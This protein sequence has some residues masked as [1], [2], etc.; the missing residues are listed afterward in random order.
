MAGENDK[1]GGHRECMEDFIEIYHREPCLWR[2]K[3]QCY[4]DRNMKD[5]AYK[6]LIIIYKEID[7]NATHDMVVKKNNLRRAYRKELKKVN[8]S[9]KSVIGEDEVYIPKLWYFHFFDFL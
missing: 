1:R 9:K 5:A 7:P 8:D 3:S 2:V 6:K 4:H